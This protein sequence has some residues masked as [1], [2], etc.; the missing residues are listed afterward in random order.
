M[1]G[2]Q[3]ADDL[4]TR[5]RVI[6]T[7]QARDAGKKLLRESNLL[8]LIRELKQLKHWPNNRDEFE[9]EKAFR[10]IEFKFYI[11]GKWIRVF[12]YQDDSRKV[13]WV[14]R[15]FAKKTNQLTTHQQVSV[16]TAVSRLEQEIRLYTRRKQQELSARRNRLRVIEGGRK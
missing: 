16:E 3:M 10:A 8:W 1:E 12:V 14:I 7:K 9:Y 5:Y 4:P 11:E 15:A 2:F 6:A 13:M